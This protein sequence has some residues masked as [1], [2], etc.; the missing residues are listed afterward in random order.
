MSTRASTDIVSDETERTELTWTV[1]LNGQDG[2]DLT[3]Y[4]LGD[5]TG[6]AMS[7]ELYREDAQAL[8]DKLTADLSL[9][10]KRL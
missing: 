7:V 4:T 10:P 2:A 8:I 9:I 5:I 3:I 6:P 1:D